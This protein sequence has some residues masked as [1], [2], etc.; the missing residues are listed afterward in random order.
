MAYSTD[1][2]R[3]YTPSFNA[4]GA[5]RK[6]SSQSPSRN[7]FQDGVSALEIGNGFVPYHELHGAG[8]AVECDPVN[9]R[10]SL[11]MPS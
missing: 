3:A 9:D 11:S 7:P 10:V 2:S 4:R 5:S 6:L 8:V 1:N